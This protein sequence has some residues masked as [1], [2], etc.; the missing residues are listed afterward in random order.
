MARSTANDILIRAIEKQ[1]RPKKS[2]YTFRLEKSLA[3]DFK[4]KCKKKKISA[5]AVLEEFFRDFL[6]N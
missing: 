4:A 5:S 3:D 1:K 6:G 2:S